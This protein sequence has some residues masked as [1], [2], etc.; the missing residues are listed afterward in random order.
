M[1]GST[2]IGKIA[3]EACHDQY[4]DTASDAPFPAFSRTDARE[5]LV[6]AE[7]RTADVSPRVVCP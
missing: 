1:G 3:D 5:E 6:S 2:H 7:E 4:E